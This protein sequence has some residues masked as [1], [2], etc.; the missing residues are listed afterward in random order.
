[1]TVEFAFASNLLEVAKEMDD[2][3]RKQLPFAAAASVTHAAREVMEAEVKN[4]E[5]KLNIRSRWLLK[6]WKFQGA[7]KQDYPNFTAYVGHRDQ[8]MA[9]QEHGNPARKARAAKRI[10][11]P[12]KGYRDANWNAKGAI[13]KGKRPK[14]LLNAKK[15]HHF[16]RGGL[17]FRRDGEKLKLVYSLRPSVRI[18]AALGAEKVAHEVFAEQFFVQ[19]EINVEAAVKSARSRLGRFSSEGGR[20]KFQQSRAQ[21]LLSRGYRVPL[22]ELQRMSPKIAGQG[23]DMV[24]WAQRAGHGGLLD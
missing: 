1:M 8:I 15:K 5:A 4:T 10:G 22:R 9:D 18:T 2:L 16:E 20:L 13:P 14:A 23:V 7:K 24:R 21:V 6:G 11:V 17:V 19:F 12:A 3:A